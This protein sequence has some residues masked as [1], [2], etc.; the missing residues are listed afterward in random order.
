MNSDRETARWNGHIGPDDYSDS[1]IWMRGELGR[2]K[3]LDGRTNVAPC[4]GSNIHVVCPD[5]GVNSI[6]QANDKQPDDQG[7][8]A[9]IPDPQLV[10]KRY[11]HEHGPNQRTHWQFRVTHR[12]RARGPTHLKFGWNSG[13]ASHLI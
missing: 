9:P 6:D 12:N 1:Y 8:H 2:K 7:D 3:R 13:R 10:W 4:K 5:D 11:K